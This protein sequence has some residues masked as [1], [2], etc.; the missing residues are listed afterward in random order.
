MV[1]V[2]FQAVRNNRILQRGE[3]TGAQAVCQT[4]QTCIM[5]LADKRDLRQASIEIPI[6]QAPELLVRHITDILAINWSQ[7]SSQ[8]AQLLSLQ[9]N[10]YVFRAYL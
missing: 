4:R 2:S 3:P 6:R 5:V 7:N 1:W 10:R 9:L 8:I